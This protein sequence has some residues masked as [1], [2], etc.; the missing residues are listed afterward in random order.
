MSR[1]RKA[2]SLLSTTVKATSTTRKA[3]RKIS[4]TTIQEPK[5]GASS[6]DLHPSVGQ[7]LAICSQTNDELFPGVVTEIDSSNGD[8]YFEI[9]DGE[10]K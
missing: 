8:I 5:S 10:E 9:D 2:Q 1:K 7:H 3:S 6:N 4:N